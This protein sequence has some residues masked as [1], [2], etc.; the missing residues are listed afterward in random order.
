MSIRMSI[1]VNFARKS[2]LSLSNPTQNEMLTIGS[3]NWYINPFLIILL[4]IEGK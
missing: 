4:L 1:I 2:D 3:I